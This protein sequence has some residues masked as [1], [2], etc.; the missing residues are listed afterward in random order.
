MNGNSPSWRRSFM[1]NNM[2]AFFS[3]RHVKIENFALK[4]GKNRRKTRILDGFYMFLEEKSG[5]IVESEA[6]NT[7]LVGTP[8]YKFENCI[9]TGVML[10]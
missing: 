3:K 4:I 6:P 5:D 9:C 7:V 1:F 10:Y 8:L 2:K